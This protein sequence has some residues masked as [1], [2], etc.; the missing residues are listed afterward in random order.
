L[1]AA[2][3]TAIPL[4]GNTSTG[5]INGEFRNFGPLAGIDRLDRADEISQHMYAKL[6]GAYGERRDVLRQAA[7]PNPNPALR[8]SGPIRLS[9]PMASASKITSPPAAWH[10]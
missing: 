5:L 1:N 2:P 3:S 9:Y 10:I 7:A 4:A 8:N 6:L